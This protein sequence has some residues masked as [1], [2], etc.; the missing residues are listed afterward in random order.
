MKSSIEIDQKLIETAMELSNAKTKKDVVN[1]ALKNLVRVLK[2]KKLLD[3]YGKTNI[4]KTLI[5]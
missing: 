5:M 4:R 2:K 1:L 3:L